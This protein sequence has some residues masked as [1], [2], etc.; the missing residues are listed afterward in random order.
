MAET[1]RATLVMRVLPHDVELE[2][3]WCEPRGT[4]LG[5]QIIEAL[6]EFC[7]ERRC[8]LHVLEVENPEFFRRFDWPMDFGDFF[9]YEHA[10]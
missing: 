9:L 1:A 7:D 5:T 4:G 10:E 8:D 6:K 2:S 3:I